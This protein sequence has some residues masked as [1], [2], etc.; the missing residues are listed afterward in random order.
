MACRSGKGSQGASR[1]A[2]PEV[3]MPDGIWLWE[4]AVSPKAVMVRAE[5]AGASQAVW[6]QC[7]TS[8]RCGLMLTLAT[9]LLLWVLAVT[10]DSMHREIKAELSA[11]VENFSGTEET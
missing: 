11:L 1:A 5:H 9:N 7:G 4:R 8:S 6:T 2:S 3:L 10:N